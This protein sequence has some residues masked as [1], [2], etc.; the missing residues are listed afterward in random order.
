[1]EKRT[2]TATNIRVEMHG[3][4][5]QKREWNERKSFFC[6]KKHNLKNKKK[7]FFFGLGRK[8]TFSYIPV[9]LFP[10]PLVTYFLLPIPAVFSAV[11]LFFY[12]FPPFSILALISTNVAKAVIYGR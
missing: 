11:Y 4:K 9:I 12:S 7:R 5:I 8:C 2:K 1:M 10:A 6:G 3:K